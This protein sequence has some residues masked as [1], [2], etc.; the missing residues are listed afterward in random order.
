L[1]QV[2]PS[3]KTGSQEED[4]DSQWSEDYNT[5]IPP[6]SQVDLVLYEDPEVDDS[7][8]T[9]LALK[10]RESTIFTYASLWYPSLLPEQLISL[11]NFLCVE[12]L[13]LNEGPIISKN[14]PSP[15]VKNAEHVL[16]KIVEGLAMFDEK[17]K[18]R[19]DKSKLQESTHL[20]KPILKEWSE[21]IKEWHSRSDLFCFLFIKLLSLDPPQN[22]YLELSTSVLFPTSPAQLPSVMA[23]N[24]SMVAPNMLSPP[25]APKMANPSITSSLF[26]I[27]DCLHV[28]VLLFLQAALNATFVPPGFLQS[29]GLSPVCTMKK[30]SVERVYNLNVYNKND[31]DDE[32]N[33]RNCGLKYIDFV[34][35]VEEGM[36]ILDRYFHK[37]SIKDKGKPNAK[38]LSQSAGNNSEKGKEIQGSGKEEKKILETGDEMELVYDYDCRIVDALFQFLSKTISSIPMLAPPPSTSVTVVIPR[39]IAPPNSS[40]AY[41]LICRPFVISLV[42]HLLQ[43]IVMKVVEQRDHANSR[44]QSSLGGTLSWWHSRWL[45][46]IY[47]SFVRFLMLYFS[48]RHIIQGQKDGTPEFVVP[49]KGY[50]PFTP[51]LPGFI[52]PSLVDAG[53]NACKT[54]DDLESKVNHVSILLPPICHVRSIWWDDELRRGLNIYITH[55]G[56]QSSKIVPV[57]PKSVYDPVPPKTIVEV[58]NSEV[59][60]SHKIIHPPTGGI[61]AKQCFFSMEYNITD[62][63]LFFRMP[64]NESL[65][66]LLKPPCRVSRRTSQ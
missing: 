2:S 14:R 4:D 42:C 64:E 24:P 62:E 21:Q 22:L 49:L 41:S 8:R 28:A 12:E 51:Y 37:K 47:I 7:Q 56:K 46:D 31:K 32:K 27:N 35:G 34:G 39:P 65:T 17:R 19:R 59:Y 52:I 50:S 58:P 43:T 44:V 18:K 53:S 48:Q 13:G 30:K 36:D 11:M 3:K 38:N 33:T 26:F 10:N 55:V 66:S 1:K 5:P 6:A 57:A 29:L 61:S 25:S 54:L 15:E 16:T 45:Q 9:I 23:P 20:L 40:V 60:F 63:E